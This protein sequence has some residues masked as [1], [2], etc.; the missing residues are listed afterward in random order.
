LWRALHEQHDVV[1]FD[2]IVDELLDTHHNR[3]SWRRRNPLT[4]NP[5]RMSRIYVVQIARKAHAITAMPALHAKIPE[6][7]SAAWDLR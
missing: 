7:A 4:P 1:G 3:P 6:F 2:L 5:I